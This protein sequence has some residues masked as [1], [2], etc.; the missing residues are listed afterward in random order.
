M[1]WLRLSN[2]RH[3]ISKAGRAEIGEITPDGFII[4]RE[5]MFPLMH[6]A[7][8]LDISVQLDV[9]IRAAAFLN[10]PKAAERCG[11]RFTAEEA[12]RILGAN[13]RAFYRLA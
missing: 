4:A 12:S 9:G 6:L 7:S 5:E 1:P 11:Y 3:A 13:A 2:D 8:R 10:Q